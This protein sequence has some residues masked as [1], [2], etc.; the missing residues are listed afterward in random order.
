MKAL[1]RRL[2]RWTLIGL[3]AA[4]GGAAWLD[5]AGRRPDLLV[6]DL[7]SAH[8]ALVERLSAA[9]TVIERHPAD[10]EASDTELAIEAARRG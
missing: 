7:D 5:G 1:G 4:D 9:G 10:K 6:G 8:H 3:V 2:L